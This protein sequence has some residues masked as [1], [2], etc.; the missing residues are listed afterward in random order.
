MVT[1]LKCGERSIVNPSC[2]NVETA[3]DKTLATFSNAGKIGNPQPSKRLYR[4]PLGCP[5]HPLLINA[6]QSTSAEKEHIS[7][8]SL[9]DI[10][11]RIYVE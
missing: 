5:P 9:D 4:Y 3:L 8:V 10:E 11:N 2:E 6:R 1:V 7:V